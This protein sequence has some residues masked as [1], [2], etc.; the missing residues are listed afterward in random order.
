MCLIKLEQCPPSVATSAKRYQE[1]MVHRKFAA[2][3]L[4]VDGKDFEYY[5]SSDTKGSEK[6]EEEEENEQEEE[7]EDDEYNVWD[8][9]PYTDTE[10]SEE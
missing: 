10:E 4:I 8:E 7:E 3:Q 9:C 1:E 6:S 2:P 5:S